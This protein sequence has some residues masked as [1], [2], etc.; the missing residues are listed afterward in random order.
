M[1]NQSE[2]VQPNKSNNILKNKSFRKV[3]IAETSGDFNLYKKSESSK[4]IEQIK[5]KFNLTGE[6]KLGKIENLNKE[7]GSAN[8]LNSD[9]RNAL[10]IKRKVSQ[11]Q[12]YQPQTM[13][14]YNLAN[15]TNKTNEE[16]KPIQLMKTR[17]GN[18]SFIKKKIA[19]FNEPAKKHFK[20]DLYGSKIIIF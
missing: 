17:S 10:K 2:M 1:K 11:E 20:I 9:D 4:N 19:S 7:R 5:R 13:N 14:I 8:G 15:K 16:K 18:S 3:E 12:Q 6:L